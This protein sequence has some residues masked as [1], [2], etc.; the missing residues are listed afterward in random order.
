MRPKP[1]RLTTRKRFDQHRTRSK[2]TGRGGGLVA[3]L[4]GSY[5]N[6]LTGQGAHDGK[7]AFR[8]WA[9][10]EYGKPWE[11]TLHNGNRLQRMIIRLPRVQTARLIKAARR[12]REKGGYDYFKKTTQNKWERTGAEG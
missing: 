6:P 4:H 2:N 3:M 1:R 11:V 7:L 9:T 10:G 8:P 5:G 12:W